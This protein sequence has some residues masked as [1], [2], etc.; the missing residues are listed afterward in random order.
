MTK[1]IKR[2]VPGVY[3]DFDPFAPKI[4]DVIT[5]DELEN[6]Y[7]K[8][9]AKASGYAFFVLRLK[10]DIEAAARKSG[11]PVA[12]RIKR[13]DLHIIQGAEMSEYCAGRTDAAYKRAAGY[14]RK[15]SD[16]DENLL[17]K[18]ETK[19]H[20][21]RIF[22][23]Q[24][25]LCA[26]AAARNR[27]RLGNGKIETMKQLKGKSESSVP[28]SNGG[29]AAGCPVGVQSAFLDIVNH[30]RRDRFETEKQLNRL[31]QEELE[32]RKGKQNENEN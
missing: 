5:K 27:L 13:G 20:D 12:T 25:Q 7:Q 2:Q 21:R 4:G 9:T 32:K 1:D 15:L 3:V 8:N 19:L 30:G 14:T 22:C 6:L 16:V 10:E 11:A 26:V 23:A 29:G 28:K 17:T 24:E 31:L 18:D